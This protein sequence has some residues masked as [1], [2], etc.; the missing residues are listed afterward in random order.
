MPLRE[1]MVKGLQVGPARGRRVKGVDSVTGLEEPR[2][3][4]F[5]RFLPSCNFW[6]L[7]SSLPPVLDSFIFDF[8]SSDAEHEC[9]NASS[10]QPVSSEGG[11]AFVLGLLHHD[12]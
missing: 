5:L 9:R 12:N 1:F 11:L 2:D 10:G 6:F 4:R 7:F 8:S 3:A